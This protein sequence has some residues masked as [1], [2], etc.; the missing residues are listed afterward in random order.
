MDRSSSDASPPRRTTLSRSLSEVPQHYRALLEQP[1]VEVFQHLMLEH[2][3]MEELYKLYYEGNEAFFNQPSTLQRLT[4]RFGL[5]A[6]ENETKTFA[7]L[8]GIY[9]RLNVTV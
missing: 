6:Y 5:E 9:D 2:L 8:L 3:G 4:E 7:A 1:G